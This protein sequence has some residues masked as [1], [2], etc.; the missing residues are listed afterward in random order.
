MGRLFSFKVGG[1]LQ[2]D[3]CNIIMFGEGIYIHNFC[4]LKEGG[5]KRGLEED[6]SLDEAK[7]YGAVCVHKFAVE[8]VLE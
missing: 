2:D 1:G 7:F 5:F 4:L 3:G 6:N 8:V